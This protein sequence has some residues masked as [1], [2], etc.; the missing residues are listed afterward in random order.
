MRER[1]VISYAIMYLAG[2]VVM[3]T[4]TDKVTI[5]SH[6]LMRV[7]DK[8]SVL[9]NTQTEHYFGLDAMGTRMWKAVTAAPNIE[10]GF[11]QLLKDF[12]VEPKQ[13]REDLTELLEKLAQNGLVTMTAVDTGAVRAT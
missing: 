7:L 12:P 9:L 6:V 8:E 11:Q 10:N 4:F 2:G 13:L 3:F 5:P 1:R